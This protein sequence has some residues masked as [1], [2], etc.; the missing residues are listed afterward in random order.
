MF[1]AR[2]IVCDDISSIIVV[3]RLYHVGSVG[4][5]FIAMRLDV[6][7]LQEEQLLLI[8]C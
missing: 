1:T 2:R 5:N 6:L 8:H 3:A 4:M 7:R